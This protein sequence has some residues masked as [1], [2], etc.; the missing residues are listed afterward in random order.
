MSFNIEIFGKKKYSK[1]PVKNQIVQILRRS[2][3]ATIQVKICT[4]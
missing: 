1:E 4:Y 3:V 2:D